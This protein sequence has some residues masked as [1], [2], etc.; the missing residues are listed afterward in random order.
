MSLPKSRLRRPFL[1]TP[2][3]IEA[4]RRRELVMHAQKGELLSFEERQRKAMLDGNRSSYDPRALREAA[5]MI[6]ELKRRYGVD[7]GLE[8]LRRLLAD[9]DKAL[10]NTPN[11]LSGPDVR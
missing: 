11:P 10:T 9:G 1:V 6:E 7:T 5:E 3:E 8:A 2:D 4:Q